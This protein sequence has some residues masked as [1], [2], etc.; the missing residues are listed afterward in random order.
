M[1]LNNYIVCLI[2]RYIVTAVI[3]YIDYRIVIICSLESE[4]TS[5]VVSKL[6]P[7]KRDYGILHKDNELSTYLKHLLTVPH[8]ATVDPEE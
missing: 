6:L 7:Y 2:L 8:R 5:H 1:Q 3:L 4:E